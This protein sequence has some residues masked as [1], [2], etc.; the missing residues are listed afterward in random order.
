MK[1]VVK[2][3]GTVSMMTVLVAC[4]GVEPQAG[5]Y[6]V[7][8]DVTEREDGDG[9][10]SR[11][12]LLDSLGQI[13]AEEEVQGFESL[14]DSEVNAILKK[15]RVE[16]RVDGPPNIAPLPDPVKATSQTLANDGWGSFS[17]QIVKGDRAEV[18]LEV[19]I[20]LDGDEGQELYEMAYLPIHEARRAGMEVQGEIQTDENLYD[21][22]YQPI[23]ASKA[24]GLVGVSQ[25][26]GQ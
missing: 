26:Q 22:N 16:V 23:H 12:V 7:Q 2:I 24:T 9:L 11:I 21:A 1:S 14:T 8:V 18:A 6:E 19:T 5:T 25:A 10:T 3:M 20:S 17:G 15:I 13:A 4:G